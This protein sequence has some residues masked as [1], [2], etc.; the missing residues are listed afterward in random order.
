MSSGLADPKMKKPQRVRDARASDNSACEEAKHMKENTTAVSRVIIFRQAELL[1][2]E[3]DGQPFVPMKPVV[4][5]MGLSWQPQHEKLKNG[6]FSSVITE[7]V[8]TGSDGKRYSMACLPLR[9]LAGWLMSIHPAKVRESIRDSVVAYQSE[10][11]DVLWAYW[12][13][14]MAVRSDNRTFETVLGTTI[15]IDGFHVLG[16]VIAGKV[17]ALPTS[18]Q[19]RA[20]MKLWAQVHAAFNVR[21]AEDIPA[22]EMASARNFIGSYSME[23]EW[24]EAKR[25]EGVISFDADDAQAI[26][27]ILSHSKLLVTMKE[28]M[29]TAG[30]AL[31]SP[32]LIEAFSH[33]WDI[34]PHLSHLSK[35]KAGELERIHME[36]IGGAR[37]ALGTFA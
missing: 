10:C 23:G 5:G 4:E 37:A 31:C 14:G 11:D 30:R 9:K 26:H 29:H 22:S 19:R 8:T 16:S 12:N 6:R 3:H 34:Q 15:G 24:I 32:F 36:R 33:L 35:T 28:Q 27:L 21:R 13:E 18:V 2:V 17:R 25:S 7:I 20:T 1:L